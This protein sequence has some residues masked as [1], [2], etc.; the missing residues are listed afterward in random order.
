VRK[1]PVQAEEET[2]GT[3]GLMQE[4]GFSFP[5]A[6]GVEL[7][8]LPSDPYRLSVVAFSGMNCVAR[9]VE[10]GLTVRTEIGAGT[11]PFSKIAGSNE[12]R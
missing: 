8:N 3:I 6:M 5:V 11:I 2:R 7:F 10:R 1:I 4:C 12:S 9:A